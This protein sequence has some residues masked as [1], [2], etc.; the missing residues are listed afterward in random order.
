MSITFN[1]IEPREII[2]AQKLNDI[3]NLTGSLFTD[4]NMRHGALQRRHF[5]EPKTFNAPINTVSTGSST[6]VTSSTGWETVQQINQVNVFRDR[7]E[8]FRCNFQA[9]VSG[10]TITGISNVQK[11]SQFA[12]FRVWLDG[13]GQIGN[14]FTLGAHGVTNGNGGPNNSITIFYEKLLMRQY[15]FHPGTSNITSNF[16]RL[17]G[18][19]AATGIVPPEAMTI[20]LSNRYGFSIRH[21]E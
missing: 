13:V 5:E 19:V 14:I 17:E 7:P 12:L 2:E 9:E 20:E 1:T 21:K 6:V 3:F 10:S 16:F 18:R 4:E 11:A 15:Y 8:V